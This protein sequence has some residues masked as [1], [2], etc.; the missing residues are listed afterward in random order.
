MFWKE[1]YRFDVDW[2]LKKHSLLLFYSFILYKNNVRII[3]YAV[4]VIICIFIVRIRFMMMV[5]LKMYE[6]KNKKHG[7]ILNNKNTTINHQFIKLNSRNF[8]FSERGLAELTL[9]DFDEIEVRYIQVMPLEV[10]FTQIFSKYLITEG[11]QKK[12][13]SKEEKKKYVDFLKNLN[14]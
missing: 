11:L 1:G 8:K 9:R 3:F 7:L 12:H 13:D 14:I 6:L 10:N 5:N 2:L 4:S